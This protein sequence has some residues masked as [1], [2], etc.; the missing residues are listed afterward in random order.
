VS[1]ARNRRSAAFALD[2]DLGECIESTARLPEHFSGR[3]TEP[4]RFLQNEPET[5]S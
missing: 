3:T 5:V 2:L 1:P 4:M